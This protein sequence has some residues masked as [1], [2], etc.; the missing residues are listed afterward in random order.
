LSASERAIV[1]EL[2]ELVREGRARMM[3][4]VR[5]ELLSG[6]KEPAQYERLR[7][8]LRSFPD[9]TIGTSD[10]EAAAKAANDCRSKGIGF[11]PVDILVCA[12]ALIRQWLIFTTDPDFKSYAKLLPI[13]LH[14]PRR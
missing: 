10:Y 5:Q 13:K 14:V 1:A 12:V 11:S 9:E 7:V 2:A 3:G 6:I 8:T 4:P